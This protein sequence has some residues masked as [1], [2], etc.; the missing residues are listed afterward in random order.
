MNLVH[1]Y[2]FEMSVIGVTMSEIDTY[3]VL[4]LCKY[5][6]MC[7]QR[8]LRLWIFIASNSL[9]HVR[10]LNYCSSTSLLLFK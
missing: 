2:N 10:C 5:M 7:E 1:S 3:C 6:C 9:C 4:N 8:S